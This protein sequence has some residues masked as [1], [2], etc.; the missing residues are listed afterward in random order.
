MKLYGYYRSSASY[1]VRI[2]LNVKGLQWD[3]MP[4]RLDKGEQLGLEHADRNPMQLVPVLDTGEALLAQ[5]VA[6]AEYLETRYPEPP[7]LPADDVA[8]ARVR[9]MVQIVASDIQPIANLR[10]LQYIRS[11]YDLDDEQV[12]EWARHWIGLGFRAFEKR[13]AEFSTSGRFAF[14]DSLSLADVFL[15]PQAYNAL[16]F[17]L[18]MTPFA[19]IRGIVEHCSTIDAVAAAHPSLQPDAPEQSAPVT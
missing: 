4:V 15:M 18:D 2:I 12:A 1:R 3:Y 9:D 10:V 8:R 5:S 17:D 11:R 6:I 19:T 7:L 13:A 14:G 16:R